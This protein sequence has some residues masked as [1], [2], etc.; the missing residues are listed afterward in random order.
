M[1]FTVKAKYIRQFVKKHFKTNMDSI[2]TV[3]PL[4]NNFM[5]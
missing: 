1:S 4:L 5:P 2:H 3:P